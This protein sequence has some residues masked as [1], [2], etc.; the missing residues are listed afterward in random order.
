MAVASRDLSALARWFDTRPA[1]R[2]LGMRCDQVEPGLAR[3]V[4][5]VSDELAN[6]N[7][8]VNGG[9]ITAFADQAGGIAVSTVIGPEEYAS[10]VQLDVHFVRPLRAL[11][12]VAEGRVRKRGRAIAYIT[13]EI[14]DAEGELCA[15]GTGAWSVSST[16]PYRYG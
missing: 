5:E 6:P 2:H 4:M 14:V 13:I 16:T 11:P 1:S 10:T 9:F 15:L 7:G 3:L 8:S 12:A